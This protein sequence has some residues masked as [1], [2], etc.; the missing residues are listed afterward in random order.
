MSFIV[1]TVVLSVP[2]AV[3]AE[4]RIVGNIRASDL[5]R[6]ASQ[7]QDLAQSFT[8]DAAGEAPPDRGDTDAR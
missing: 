2:R 5:H 7:V 1:H 6:L 8:S 3:H 4:V